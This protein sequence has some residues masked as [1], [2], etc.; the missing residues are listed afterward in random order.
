MRTLIAFAA[1][2]LAA[3]AAASDITDGRSLSNACEVLREATAGGA[4]A[5]GDDP[6]RVWL[7]NFFTVYKEAHDARLMAYLEGGASAAEAGPCFRPPDFISFVDV[8]GLVVARGK[9]QPDL[10]DGPAERLVLEAMAAA[11]PCDA[12][13]DAAA[14]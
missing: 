5:P 2:L 9:A 14:P 8:A 4:K 12:P 3:P 1:L 10:L 13:P 11:Y 6:C 7:F